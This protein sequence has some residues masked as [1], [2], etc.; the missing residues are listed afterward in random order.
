[1]T[2]ERSMNTNLILNTY[3]ENLALDSITTRLHEHRS[4]GNT[5]YT[6]TLTFKSRQATPL[7]IE[8]PN[9]KTLDSLLQLLTDLKTEWEAAEQA[10]ELA[11]AK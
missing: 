4:W 5:D 10:L 8:I 1:M 2:I 3:I 6:A 7:D 9:T 11:K